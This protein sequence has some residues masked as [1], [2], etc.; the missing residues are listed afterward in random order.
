M[1]NIKIETRISLSSPSEL[2][3]TYS[4]LMKQALQATEHAYA[5][6]SHFQVG[7]AVLLDNGIIVTGSNQENAAYPSGLCAERVALFHAGHQYPNIPVVA[8]AIAASTQGKQ[9]ENISPCGACRQVL[10]ETEQ[11]QRIK[12][13][14]LLCG[15]NEV[16]MMD[17]AEDL[18]PLCFGKKDLKEF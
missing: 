4:V 15:S 9:V 7:A 6:Y 5:P 14:V 1:K 3:E 8:L 18:L 16:V 10:L 12:I 2:E 13:K 17:S 11:R